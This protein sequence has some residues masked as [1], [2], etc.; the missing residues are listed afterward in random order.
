MYF[1]EAVK[2]FDKS[3][4][5]LTGKDSPDGPAAS[6]GAPFRGGRARQGRR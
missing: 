3:S 5:R 4:A 1:P 2:L 6:G